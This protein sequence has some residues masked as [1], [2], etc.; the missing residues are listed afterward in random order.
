MQSVPQPI[1]LMLIA[2]CQIRLWSI[3]SVHSSQSETLS[4][5]RYTTAAG[6]A[7]EIQPQRDSNPVLISISQQVA[8][9]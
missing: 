4:M 7:T 6:T 9:M 3:V 5:A 8:G 1:T 2:S